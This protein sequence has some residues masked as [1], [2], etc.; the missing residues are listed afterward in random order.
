MLYSVRLRDRGPNSRGFVQLPTVVDDDGNV[1]T[2]PVDPSV[3]SQ[4]ARCYIESCPCAVLL[5]SPVFS[6]SRDCVH[7]RAAI[8][9]STDTEPLPINSSVIDSLSFVTEDV[10]TIL[11]H[12][13][14]NESCPAVQRITRSVLVVRSQPTYDCSLEF[15]HV[16]FAES[17]RTRGDST[18]KF[19]CDCRIFQVHL[20][21][22]ACLVFLTVLSTRAGMINL[23]RC[24]RRS[25]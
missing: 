1:A 5:N 22:V 6:I 12:F 17:V 23:N 7:I 9:C 21:N 8:A 2:F 11:R 4:A 25:I 18:P 3:L 15:V 20:I 19:T 13:I 24:D 10:R 16:T 14:A